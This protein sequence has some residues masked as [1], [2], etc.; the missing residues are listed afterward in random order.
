[1]KKISLSLSGLLLA[2]TAMIAPGL[3]A[4]QAAPAQ[5]PQ[6]QATT[7]EEIVVLGRFIPEPLRETSEVAAF[8]TN[9]D[10]QRT[11]DSTAA[12]ALTRVTGLTIVESRFV[13]VRGLGERYSSALLNGS[14]LPS[15]EPLQRV[16]PLDLFPSNILG[17]VTVQ[18]T[19]S[20]NYPGEFGGGVIDLQT[21][22]APSEPFFNLQLS[23]GYN[24][25]TTL[26]DNLTYYGSQSDWT[27]FD[28]GTRDVPGP[29]AI[30]FARGRQIGPGNFTD[31]ELQDIGQSLVNAP[32]RL[33][34][35]DES[36]FNW[37]V[38][39]EGGFSHDTGVGTLGVVVAAGTTT[40]GAPA[41]AS[42]RSDCWT[43]DVW[44]RPTAT[45]SSP[46]RTMSS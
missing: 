18:K 10:I 30:A 40:A 41:R 6:D 37:G 23:T 24:S 8:L 38:E 19:Y 12:E 11:G 36:P 1:M 13:Y 29:L 3:A 32:L 15:P 45:P 22:E 28:S 4:A 2:T 17:G 21:I 31:E 46:A 7:V 27:G 35:F 9:E 14:P 26:R 39:A 5:D 34:Q 16:V 20:P 25:E 42:R 43:P 44:S 33:L